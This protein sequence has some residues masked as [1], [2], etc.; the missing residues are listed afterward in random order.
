MT[1]L[2]DLT[3]TNKND[4]RDVADVLAEFLEELH[5][6]SRTHGHKDSR[7]QPQHAMTPLTVQDLD[8]ASNQF[9]RE[10]EQQTRKVSTQRQEK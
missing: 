4:R 10:A 7:N 6:S 2:E 9:K 1:D 5:T 3:G 8:N